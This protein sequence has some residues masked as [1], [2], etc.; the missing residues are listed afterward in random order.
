MTAS[1][2]FTFGVERRG[3]EDGLGAGGRVALRGKSTVWCGALLTSF[4]L[5]SVWSNGGGCR[6]YPTVFALASKRRPHP[7]DFSGVVTADRCQHAY[8]MI[9]YIMPLLGVHCSLLG[10]IVLFVTTVDNT[11]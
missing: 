8:Y 9:L 11:S 3:S 2:R 5:D 1:A 7:P 10:G 6:P 4:G